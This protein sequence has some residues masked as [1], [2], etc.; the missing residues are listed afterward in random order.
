MTAL[1]SEERADYENKLAEGL[2]RG[3]LLGLRVVVATFIAR[4]SNRTTNH[5]RTYSYECIKFNYKGTGRV[6]Q[7]RKVRQQ[8]LRQ[9]SQLQYARE[10]RRE[11]SL[12]L[13]H[14][15]LSLHTRLKTNALGQH[16]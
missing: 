6:Q 5:L 4:C 7:P 1:K 3:L 15:L 11:Q 13:R 2:P 9:S 12:R 10:K 14:D 16:I 8:L